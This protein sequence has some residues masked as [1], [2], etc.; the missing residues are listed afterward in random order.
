MPPQPGQHGRDLGQFALVRRIGGRT[1]GRG[2]GLIRT[3]VTPTA[4]VLEPLVSR[5]SRP[6]PGT[7]EVDR[8]ALSFGGLRV[9]EDVSVSASTGEIVGII[10]P[11][12]AGK[13]TLFNVVCGFVRPEAGRVLWRGKELRRH[14]PHDLARLGIARTLQGVGLFPHLSALDN[15]LVGTTPIGRRGL[16]SELLGLSPSSRDERRLRATAM[17]MLELLKVAEYA[18]RVPGTL[19]YPVQKRIALARALVSDPALVLM[20]EPASGLSPADI[21][22]LAAVFTGLRGVVG[23]LIVEHNIELVMATCT[24]I[25]VLDFGRVI[26]SGSPAEIRA[27]PAVT[28]AYL[29]EPLA[30]KDADARD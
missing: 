25:V 24:R 10:G 22:D 11:N 1:G 2:S 26:A 19:P 29:G 14:Q 3:A 4:A 8:V 6:P 18:Q 28:T 20:D 5:A 7:L 9:L 16:V 17:E 13:T 30:A 15:V 21:S 12:G 27:N 23:M